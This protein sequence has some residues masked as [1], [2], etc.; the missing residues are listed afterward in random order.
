MA[1]PTNMAPTHKGASVGALGRSTLVNTTLSIPMP[2]GAT[3]PPA[4]APSSPSQASPSQ[5]GTSQ[6]TQA[7]A[8]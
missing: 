6:T 4:P 5:S 8:P 2:S 7:A 3:P 1:N